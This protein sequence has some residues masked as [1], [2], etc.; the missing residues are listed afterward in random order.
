MDRLKLILG[1]L[2]LALGAGCSST[3]LEPI[4]T[5]EKIDLPRF[6]GDWYVISHIPT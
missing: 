3:G 6:M 1:A 4:R 2:I 5:A